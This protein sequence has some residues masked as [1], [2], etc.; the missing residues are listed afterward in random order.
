MYGLKVADT[1]QVSFGPV[2]VLMEV[3]I[4]SS[5]EPYVSLDLHIMNFLMQRH[6]ANVYIL[7]YFMDYC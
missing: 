3:K 1:D 4:I 6:S 2:L 5:S 7:I